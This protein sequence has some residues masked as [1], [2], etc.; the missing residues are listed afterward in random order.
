MKIYTS[1]FYQIRFFTPNMIPVST[2]VW[3]PKWFHDNQGPEHVFIDKRGVINGVRAPAL[4]PG[5]ALEGSC[6]GPKNCTDDPLHC[7]FL[8]GYVEQLNKLDCDDYVH[9]LENLGNKLK[10]GAR[11]EGEPVIVLIVYEAPNNMC[12]ERGALQKWLSMNGY[13]VSEWAR[14]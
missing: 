9:R 2:A 12:S 10:R 3:D 6:A 1:Y 7:S 5:E 11:F 4:H 13:E 8:Q 14:S